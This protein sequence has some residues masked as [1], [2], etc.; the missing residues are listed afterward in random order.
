MPNIR[1]SLG[2]TEFDAVPERLDDSLKLPIRTEATLGRARVHVVGVDR[3]EIVLVGRYMTADVR[4]AIEV[5]LEECKQTG[6]S[7]V[8]NDGYA[9]RDVLIRSFETTPL[10]GKTEGFSFRIELV[11]V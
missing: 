4:S 2:G 11:V 3:E 8:L 1:Y 5:L 10:V 7:A 9:D 6:A